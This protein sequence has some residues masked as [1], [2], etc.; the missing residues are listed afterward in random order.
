MFFR[1][2]RIDFKII[3]ISYFLAPKATPKKEAPAPPK[4]KN[5]EQVSTT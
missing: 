5:G 3:N 1:H 2:H 4:A